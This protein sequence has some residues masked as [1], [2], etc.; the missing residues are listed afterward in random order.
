MSVNAAG[1]VESSRYN[2]LCDLDGVKK[3]ELDRRK[4]LRL[5]QV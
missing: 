5:E 1:K 3:K 2:H 4:K